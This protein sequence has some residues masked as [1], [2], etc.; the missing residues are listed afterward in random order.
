VRGRAVS[1]RT[2][3]AIMAVM[4]RLEEQERRR[5]LRPLQRRMGALW[6]SILR[7]HADDIPGASQ[8]RVEIVLGRTLG[9]DRGV[10][11]RCDPD[12]QTLRIAVE[13]PD[14]QATLAHELAHIAVLG[15]GD[16]FR[17]ELAR[18][19]ALGV[20]GA[21]RALNEVEAGEVGRA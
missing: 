6:R 3:L 11:G 13:D 14:P 1:Y 16:A 20:P 12:T 17:A 15:H 10:V 18:L 7:A 21:D 2:E 5:V 19:E 9:L 8:Y 4:R